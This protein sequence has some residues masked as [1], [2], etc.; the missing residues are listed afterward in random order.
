M[1]KTRKGINAV[2][3]TA[4]SGFQQRTF[5]NAVDC[6]VKFGLWVQSPRTVSDPDIKG[7]KISEQ[8]VTVDLVCTRDIPTVTIVTG[9]TQHQSTTH[10]CASEGLTQR[11][12]HDKLSPLFGL[13][14]RQRR[15]HQNWE[16]LA[17]A[18]RKTTTSDV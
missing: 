11:C 7:G 8:V 18:Y 9:A 10:T 16:V 1:K 4:K 3:I 6:D 14:C 12:Q 17:C 5:A 13:A 2:E 15:K